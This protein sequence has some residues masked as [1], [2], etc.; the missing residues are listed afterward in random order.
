M[1]TPFCGELRLMSFNFPPKGWAECNGQILQINQNQHLFSLLGIQYGGDG[2]TTF[3]LPELRGRVPIHL[4]P[5]FKKQGERVGE[6]F[7]KLTEAEIPAHT[8]PIMASSR[9]GSQAMP[10]MLASSPNAYRDRVVD[11]VTPIHSETLAAAGGGQGHEN[12]HPLLVTNW[13]IALTGITPPR[14]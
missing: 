9:P 4:G 8:H 11:Q 12:R 6:E 3:G 2:I 5:V 7:H 10:A 14:P 13:C 1:A